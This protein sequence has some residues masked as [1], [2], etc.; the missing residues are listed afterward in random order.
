MPD[1]RIYPSPEALAQA[2]AELFIQ[3]ALQS[4]AHSRRFRV[5]LS[6]GSTPRLAYQRLAQLSSQP[7]IQA[8]STLAGHQLDWSRA[9]LFWG[10][11]RC[12]PPDHP[13]SNYAMA[14]EALLDQVSIPVENVHRVHGEL[15]AAAAAEAFQQD[16]YNHFGHRQGDPIP[17][18]FDLILLGLGPDGHTASLFPNSPALQETQRW[19]MAVKHRTPPTPLIDRVT[20]TLPALNAAR[21]IIFLVSGSEKA[22]RLAQVLDQAPVPASLPA[23]QVRPA[24]GE[25]IWLV[26]RE[27]A[28][29]LG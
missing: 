16:L 19:A 14:K 22:E 15:P 25:L 23:A 13:E 29:H 18:T 26:D 3:S 9:H 2:A 1:V 11:E 8:D 10:D 12:V 27:A 5:A 17:A 20:L 24:N 7:L 21:R 4:L 6:G 28:A